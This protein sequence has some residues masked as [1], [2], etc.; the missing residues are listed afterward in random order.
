MKRKPDLIALLV[1][2]MVVVACLQL[3]L[4]A[5]N[6]WGRFADGPGLPASTLF[7]LGYYRL[8]LLIPVALTALYLILRYSLK[9]KTPNHFDAFVYSLSIALLYFVAASITRPFAGPD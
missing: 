5:R 6:Y 7:V 8:L 3:T 1:H 4:R 9:D 2:G